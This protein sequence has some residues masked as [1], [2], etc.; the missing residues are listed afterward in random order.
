MVFVCALFVHFIPF[1]GRKMF[2]MC[3][4]H[5]PFRDKQEMFHACLINLLFVGVYSEH[6]LFLGWMR[7]LRDEAEQLY[8]CL[9][10]NYQ[11]LGAC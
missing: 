1:I 8:S 3:S 4:L 9:M 11:G 2:E 5:R 10:S 6:Q 7:L